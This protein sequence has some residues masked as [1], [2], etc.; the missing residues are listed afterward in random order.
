MIWLVVVA[1]IIMAAWIPIGVSLSYLDKGATVRLMIGPLRVLLYPSSKKDKE[2]QKK[3][4][5][6][7]DNASVGNQSGKG[8]SLTDFVPLVRSVISF[9][10]DFHKSLRVKYLMLSLT[11][12]GDDPCD[13]ALNY[14]KACAAMGNLWP[15][16]ERFFVI[17]KRDVKIQCDFETE[18]T[19]VV[20]KLDLTITLGRLIRLIARYGLRTFREYNI[21]KNKQKGGATL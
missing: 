14:A 5:Q 21:L 1:V 11:L 17:Q 6:P 2:K 12:A 7:K 8:G 16:L 10:V 13:L 4:K 20:A 3:E 19:L 15:Y 9:L 18:E